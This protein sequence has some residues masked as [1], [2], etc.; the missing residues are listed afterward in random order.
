MNRI[1]SVPGGAINRNK[2]RDGGVLITVLC[3]VVI[4]GFITTGMMHMVTS[5]YALAKRSGEFDAA[6]YMA[7][8][9]VNFEIRSISNNAA[10]AD[11][12]S[13][14]NPKGPFYLIPGTAYGFNVYITTRLGTVPWVAGTPGIIVST[15]LYNGVTR[16]ISVYCKTIAGT[17]TNGQYSLWGTNSGIINGNC[18]VSGDVGTNGYLVYNG[19]NTVSGNTE[20]NGPTSNFQSTPN[21]GNSYHTVHNL[22]PKVWPTVS[23]QAIN[24]FGVTGMSYVKTNNDNAMAVPPIPSNYIYLLNGSGTATF[25]GKPGGANYYVESLTCN[26]NYNIYFDNTNGPITI[27]VGPVGT[28]STFIFNGGDSA[29][30]MSADITK[31]VK[32]YVGTT[33]DIIQNGTVD[34]NCMLYNINPNGSGQFIINGNC[35]F[36]GSAICNAFTCNGHCTATYSSGYFGNSTPSYYS[37]DNVYTESNPSF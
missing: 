35:K 18:T 13:L 25:K 3:F 11:T 20:F 26:G 17:N 23:A 34:I 4:T 36:N 9:G 29:I 15:G 21:P 31:A 10:N 19:N 24:S 1:V 7:E 8:A 14:S 33:N 32:I 5:H 12:S 28:S 30:K 37:F 16:T 2:R 6:L 27:W 22:T